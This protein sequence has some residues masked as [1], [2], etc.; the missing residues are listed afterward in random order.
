MKEPHH[1]VMKKSQMM[2]F[3][4]SPHST[5]GLSEKMWFLNHDLNLYY[6]NKMLIQ[7]INKI[8]N[9]LLKLLV[10]GSYPG[11]LVSFTN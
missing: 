11:Y 9:I 7:S 2:Y 1:V 8:N 4:R 6:M 10:Y 3:V 5:K